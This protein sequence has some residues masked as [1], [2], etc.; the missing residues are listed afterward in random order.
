MASGLVFIVVR[1]KD[2]P[3]MQ[4]D[5]IDTL[6]EQV[7]SAYGATADMEALKYSDKLRILGDMVSSQKWLLVT[8]RVREIQNIRHVPRCS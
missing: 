5:D 4:I 8:D 6:A 2:M 7:F 1:L 3:N